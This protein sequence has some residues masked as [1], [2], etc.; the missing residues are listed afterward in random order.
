A[1]GDTV[2]FESTRAIGVGRA[3]TIST[4]Y[5]LGAAV[6]AAAFLDEPVTVPIAVGS[7][8][9][10]AGLVLI[11]AVGRARARGALLVRRRRGRDRVLGLGGLDGPRQA[12][13]V[14][15]GPGHRAGDPAAGR[16]DG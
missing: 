3:M 4:T 1:L 12:A 15:D 14:R 9:T 7:L 5:P 11:V 6:I 8:V 10:M 2:F 16:V 13:A